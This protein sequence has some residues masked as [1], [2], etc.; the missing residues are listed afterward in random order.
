MDNL[1]KLDLEKIEVQIDGKDLG[2]FTKMA[3]SIR[4]A[5]VPGGWLIFTAGQS[6]MSGVSFY[7]DPQHAWDGGSVH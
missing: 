4:R 3:V 2:L 6:G 7:P 1:P 5:R